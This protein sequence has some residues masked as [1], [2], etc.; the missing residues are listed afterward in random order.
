[1]NMK[2]FLVHALQAL[3][4]SVFLENKFSRNSSNK[5]PLEEQQLQLFYANVWYDEKTSL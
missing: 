5:K 1:M 4:N 2:G 3:G